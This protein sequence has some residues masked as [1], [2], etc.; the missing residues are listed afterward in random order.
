MT[1]AP[2]D[3]TVGGVSPPAVGTVR[4][5]RRRRTHRHA[6]SATDSASTSPSTDRSRDLPAGQLRPRLGSRL[7]PAADGRR[8][9]S[10]STSTDPPIDHPHFRIP[11]FR[12]GARPRVLR[13]DAGRSTSPTA[14]TSTSSV[15]PRAGCSTPRSSSATEQPHRSAPHADRSATPFPGATSDRRGALP[16][17]PDRSGRGARRRRAPRSASRPRCHR[18]L[19]GARGRDRHRVCPSSARHA[20]ARRVRFRK[21]HRPRAVDAYRE[22]QRRRSTSS[23]RAWRTY[24]P[25]F[26]SPRLAQYRPR[27]P[28]ASERSAPAALEYSMTNAISPTR[29]VHA[30]H[31]CDP[32]GPQS[33]SRRVRRHLRRALRQRHLRASWR[34]HWPSC[35]STCPSRATR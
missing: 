28:H 11:L 3:V 19:P 29:P 27:P 18:R 12:L 5:D 17:R 20:P 6:E 4:V 2:A 1:G 16:R 25:P 7:R 32:E 9:A 26:A 15:P 14:P 35:S 21:L 30:D 34:L 31:R 8:V 24:S 23:A 33:R 13:P 10:P 22:Q